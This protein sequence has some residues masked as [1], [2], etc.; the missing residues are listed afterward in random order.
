MA[1]LAPISYHKERSMPYRVN[2]VIGH[3]IVLVRW[4]VL[5]GLI[6]ATVLQLLSAFQPMLKPGQINLPDLIPPLNTTILTVLWWRITQLEKQAEY[7][8]DR[9][10]KMANHSDDRDDRE[11]HP[12][13]RR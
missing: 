12:R 13:A 2:S 9:I 3:F 1:G 7:F 5:V 11:G 6:G 8:R 4:P 10:D